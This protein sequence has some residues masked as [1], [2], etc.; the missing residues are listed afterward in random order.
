MTASPIYTVWCD[1]DG[2]TRW[3]EM[4][5]VGE[6][7]TAGRARKIMRAFGWRRIGG[8]DLC[9]DCQRVGA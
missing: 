9:R 2:C 1:G 7:Y 3:C 4:T 8:R 5:N 6:S